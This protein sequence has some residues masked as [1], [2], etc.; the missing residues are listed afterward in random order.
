MAIEKMRLLRLAG[1][2]ENIEEFVLNAFATYDLHAELAS[3]VINEGNGG[4]LLPED[5]RYQEFLAQRSVVTIDDVTTPLVEDFAASLRRGDNALRASSAARIVVSVRGFHRFALE[6]GQT[7]NDP[8]T[9]V[10]PPTLPKRLPK[11]VAYDVIEAIIGGTGD[12][13]HPRSARDRALIELLYGTGARISDVVAL[14]IDDVDLT[15]L[16]VV[17]TGKG[18][19]QRRIPLGEVAAE[20]LE[21]YLRVGRPVLAQAGKAG[22]AVFL[23]SR[24]T[25]LSRQSAWEIV[26]RAAAAGGVTVSISPHTLRHSCATHLLE[27]GADVRVVQELLGHA[28]VTT[29]QVYTLVTADSLREV[30]ALA[31]PRALDSAAPVRGHAPTQ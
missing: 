7:M 25:R 1:E 12:G 14:D 22:A 2:K 16:T 9:D 18:A 10:S 31:H 15:E 6:E 29:T 11:A 4:K 3:K 26:T 17:V 20:A 23:N 28:S 27:R 19:K 5:T 13:S 21:N 30:Y 8:A 24:G